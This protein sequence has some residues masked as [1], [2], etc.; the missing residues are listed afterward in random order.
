MW[1]AT[2]CVRSGLGAPETC[3]YVSPSL[4]PLL[5]PGTRTPAPALRHQGLR[6]DTAIEFDADSHINDKRGTVEFRK[7]VAG[8]MAMRAARVGQERRSRSSMTKGE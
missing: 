4:R 2:A 1:R 3:H 8:V 5:V 7:H 6:T